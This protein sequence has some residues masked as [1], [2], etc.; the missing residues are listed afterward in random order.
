[1]GEFPKRIR[2]RGFFLL[3][4]FSPLIAIL[5]L[6]ALFGVAPGAASVSLMVVGIGLAF[7]IWTSPASSEELQRLEMQ[8]R[9]Q[10]AAEAEQRLPP[11]VPTL[12]LAG[13]RI[14]LSGRALQPIQTA[15]ASAT[16]ETYGAKTRTVI[17]AICKQREDWLFASLESTPRRDAT[18][19]MLAAQRL[20]EDAAR[21]FTVGS[22]VTSEDG[23]APFRSGSHG[24]SVF[25]VCIVFA[26][27]AD[28]SS[29]Q[30]ESHQDTEALMTQLHTLAERPHTFE[31]F[32]SGLFSIDELTQRDPAMR[33]I[34]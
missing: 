19:I 28:I 29:H 2:V 33:G 14:A 3:L 24:D 4:G 18:Q 21:R 10:E 31:I 17:S 32:V 34:A 25:V 5:V 30:D 20:M 26:C 27:G 1:M 6:L 9:R 13:V 7:L 22:D 23:E 11:V 16:N 8:R 12:D 15:L